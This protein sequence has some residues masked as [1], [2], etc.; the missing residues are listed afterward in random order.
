MW[1]Y[2]YANL[3]HEIAAKVQKSLWYILG[4]APGLVMGNGISPIFHLLE[5]WSSS[6]PAG[7]S[8]RG[9]DSIRSPRGKILQK[10]K[11]WSE[12]YTLTIIPSN[13]STQAAG[14]IVFI[15]LWRVCDGF[16]KS[17]Y[18]GE[19]VG[20]ND[21]QAYVWVYPRHLWVSVCVWV[22]EYITSKQWL[23]SGLL[24]FVRWS[25]P[26]ASKRAPDF[27]CACRRSSTPM[28]YHWTSNN[29]RTPGRPFLGAV[30]S[31]WHP[32]LHFP[33]YKLHPFA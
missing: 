26:E 31:T 5:G 25:V 32:L 2:V 8:S 18:A 10:R 19:S 29:R 27:L 21:V 13:I 22:R 24:S 4:F 7:T 16:H 11:H 14:V 12:H 17:L 3:L 28:L 9:T 6:C 30:S 20:N 23:M 15:C 1:D 33:A